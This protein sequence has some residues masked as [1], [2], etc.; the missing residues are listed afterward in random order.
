MAEDT[1]E[2]F[3]I[4]T[5]L[6]NPQNFILQQLQY[7]ASLLSNLM[8]MCLLPSGKEGYASH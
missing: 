6:Q 4:G 1:L 8:A 7:I 3:A 5:N 2:I